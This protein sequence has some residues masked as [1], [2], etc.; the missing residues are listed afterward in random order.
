MSALGPKEVKSLGSSLEALVKELSSQYELGKSSTDTVELDQ[1]KVGRL[2]RM[3]AM[4]Q[5]K[6]AESSLASTLQ[7]LKRVRVA[8]LRFEEG[9]YGYCNECGEIIAL[10][11]LE[12]QPEAEFCIKCQTHQE[13]SA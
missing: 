6:M 2:T 9:D 11:R 3:D 8:L 4:Q 7:R 1:S 10:A 12:I 13:N 5:Q